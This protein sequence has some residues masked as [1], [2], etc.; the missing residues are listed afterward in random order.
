MGT[1]ADRDIRLGRRQ[2]DGSPG[3]APRLID[4]FLPEYQF[5]ERHSLM[6]R[7]SGETTYRALRAAD[8]GRSWII[9]LLFRLRGLGALFKSKGPRMRIR[10]DDF[11]GAGF[12]LLD[13]RFGDEIVVGLV[14]RLDPLFRGV[15]DID[16]QRFA[17]FNEPGYA[18]AALNF[19]IDPIG[20]AST[21]LST[22]TRV[23]ATDEST[24]RSFARYWW[25]V[26]PFSALTRRQMLAVVRAEIAEAGR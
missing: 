1:G 2:P 6:V 9:R 13:E 20:P 17:S 16:T 10:L 14:G 19:K 11:I 12:L 23:F 25:V 18:K 15:G 22:E 8:F 26:G 24:R 21:L 7:A 5:V 3:I 4:R